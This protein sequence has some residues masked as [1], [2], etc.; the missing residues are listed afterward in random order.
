MF[1]S[2]VKEK[3]SSR[4]VVISNWCSLTLPS[5]LSSVDSKPVFRVGTV[6]WD[7]EWSEVFDGS[8]EKLE[9]GPVLGPFVDTAHSLDS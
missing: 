5:S 8:H 1:T 4:V 6:C 7:L 3:K 2:T 9:P